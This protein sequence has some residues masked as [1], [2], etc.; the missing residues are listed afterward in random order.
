MR[1]ARQNITILLTE[2]N[3]VYLTIIEIAIHFCDMILAC[4][5]SW[6]KSFLSDAIDEFLVDQ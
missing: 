2:I 6:D 5:K 1:A 3:L 4:E